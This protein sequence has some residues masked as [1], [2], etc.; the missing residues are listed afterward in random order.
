MEFPMD[1][2]ISD[3]LNE[4]LI[5][6]I[7]DY[8]RFLRKNEYSIPTSS[9]L[10]MFEMINNTD[11]FNIEEFKM[12]S[13][14]IYC[15]TQMEFNCYDDMFNKYFFHSIKD[16]LKKDL[17]EQ[18]RLCQEK[19]S[20]IES[21]LKSELSGINRKYGRIIQ[22]IVKDIL[23]KEP[24]FIETHRKNNI[25]LDKEE[26]SELENLINEVGKRKK[27]REIITSLAKVENEGIL[28]PI[29]KDE[30]DRDKINELLQN[31]IIANINR[32]NINKLNDLVVNMASLYSTMDKAIENEKTKIKEQIERDRKSFSEEYNKAKEENLKEIERI[33]IK[34]KT[35]N[36]R[37]EFI[38]GNS[39]VIELIRNSDKTMTKLTGADYESLLYYIKLNAAKFRTK[40][41]NSMKMHKNAV[42]DIKKTMSESVKLGGV[43]IKLYYKK[44]VVKKYKL[45]CVLDI[46]G[47]V[48]KYLKILASFLFEINSVFN[49]GVEVYGFVSDLLDFSEVFRE[50]TVEE[51]VNEVSGRRGY[52]SYEIAIQ[53]FYDNCFSKVD[54]NTI[55]LYFGDAR[56]NK[57][58]PNDNLLKEINQKAKYTVWLNPEEK[59]KWNTNDSVMNLY[60]ETVN[61]VYEVNTVKQLIYF[62]N[63][64][65]INER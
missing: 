2:D 33:T 5:N 44:P 35:L 53:D 39:S 42:I 19:I 36:H 8:S 6:M 17:E 49:G 62:L 22:K 43:P 26:Q 10:M 12:I 16:G 50:N 20:E 56:N 18:K 37:E 27:E 54:N 21:N 58:K 52:S 57:N 51:A 14:S 4:V 46:S 32:N 31:L 48:S 34:E 13:K 60:G 61:K 59:V 55:I 23:V 7:L 15:K 1:K 38:P 28:K 63:N 24:K 9:N 30:I 41:G 65:S 11:V 64:F 40:L 3:N 29:I 25:E 47:S 45:M